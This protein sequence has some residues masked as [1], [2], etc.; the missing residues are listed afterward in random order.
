MGIA[1]LTALKSR[2]GF[3]VGACIV[4][5]NRVVATG[6]NGL[7]K[8]CEYNENW[9][10]LSL[11][12]AIFNAVIHKASAD[13]LHG[14]ILYTTHFPC[15]ECTKVIIQS[16]IAQVIHGELHEVDNQEIFLASQ[17]MLMKAKENKY[18]FDVKKFPENSKEKL[19]SIFKR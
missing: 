16:G 13:D 8:Y 12:H 11:C 4:K 2:I 15:S 14:C 9:S 17:N 18:G 5:D 6:Y 10:L 7:P 19:R 3:N 1:H